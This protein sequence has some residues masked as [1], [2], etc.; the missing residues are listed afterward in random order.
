MNSDEVLI[1]IQSILK[2]P[3][4]YLPDAQDPESMLT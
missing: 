3:N 2:I 4:F 1:E